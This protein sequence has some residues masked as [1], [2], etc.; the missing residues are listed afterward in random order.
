[1]DAIRRNTA[2]GVKNY[3]FSLIAPSFSSQQPVIPSSILKRFANSFADSF[4][5]LDAGIQF[6]IF[7]ETETDYE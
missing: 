4:G 3:F 2:R 5:F 1:M 7:A 6:P